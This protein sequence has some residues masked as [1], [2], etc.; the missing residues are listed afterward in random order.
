LQ[1]KQLRKRELGKQWKQKGK[2]IEKKT[3]NKND[4]IRGKN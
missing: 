1:R 3:H 2:D 4:K